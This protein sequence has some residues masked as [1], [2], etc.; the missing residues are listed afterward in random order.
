MLQV[1]HS[2]S[3]FFT[4]YETPSITLDDDCS[5]SSYHTPRV[6]DYITINDSSKVLVFSTLYYFYFRMNESL[7]ESKW[8]TGMDE[9]FNTCR[10]MQVHL[11]CY[12]I[13]TTIRTILLITNMPPP[14]LY[15]ASLYTLQ[16]KLSILFPNTKYPLNFHDPPLYHFTPLKLL[17]VKPSSLNTMSHLILKLNGLQVGLFYLIMDVNTKKH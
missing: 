6:F 17:V 1:T 12:G 4:C 11:D 3:E 2:F 10:S 8:V 5:P 14:A 16:L 15:Q 13:A 9:S 7:N